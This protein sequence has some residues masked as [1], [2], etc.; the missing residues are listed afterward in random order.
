M[1]IVISYDVPDDR[2]RAK[3]AKSLEGWGDRVQLSVFEFHLE[4]GEL[5]DLRA[6]VLDLIEPKEDNVRI[7]SLCE[8]CRRKVEVYG[9]ARLSERPDV[10]VL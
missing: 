10:Y 1:L 2:R 8:A 7:Y 4:A 3:L 6:R 9:R 5:E